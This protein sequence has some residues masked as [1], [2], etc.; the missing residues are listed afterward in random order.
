L[1]RQI[2]GGKEVEKL[3]LEQVIEAASKERKGPRGRL[4]IISRDTETRKE[5]SFTRI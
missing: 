3:A 1:Q 5:D 4:L 2:S